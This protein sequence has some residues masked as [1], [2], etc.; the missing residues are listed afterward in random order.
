VAAVFLAAVGVVRAEDVLTA[1][2][3]IYKLAFENDRVRVLEATFKP[4]AKTGEHSHPDHFVYVIKGGKMKIT[5]AGGEAQI[6]DVKPGQ[7]IWIPA[8]TH[9]GENIGPSTVKIV[10]TELKPTLAP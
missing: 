6:I 1:A 4:G 5:K 3:T 2:P 9:V 7:V 10:V 8:E